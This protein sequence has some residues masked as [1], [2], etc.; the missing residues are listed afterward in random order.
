MTPTETADQKMSEHLH[1]QHHSW[2][3][4]TWAHDFL[5]SAEACAVEP[6]THTHKPG[7]PL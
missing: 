5:H 1:D 7:E 4:S 3:T 2:C 6:T